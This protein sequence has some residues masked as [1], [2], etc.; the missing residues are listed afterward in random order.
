MRLRTVLSGAIFALTTL[1]GVGAFLYPFWMPALAQQGVMEG[2]AQDMAHAGDAAL[3]LS[4]IVALCFAVLLVEVQAQA[5]SAKA[6]A[7][8]GVLV[9]INSVLRFAEVA[10]PGPGGFSPIFLLIV[11]GGYVFGARIGFL[12]GALTLLASA[13]ITGGVGPWLPYQMLT[14]GWVGMSAPLCRGPARAIAQRVRGGE[15]MVLA[16]FGAAWG[17]LF[18]V[19]INLWFWPFTV[20]VGAMYW[21]PGVG[22]AETIRRYALFYSVTSLA[23]DLLRAAG[24]AVLIALLG[25]AV[26]RILERFRLRFDFTY[27][28]EPQTAG[29]KA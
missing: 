14:A 12:L 24:N 28:P 3:V 7:L 19:I 6:I 21:E 27:V 9:A 16:A 20:G 18:G 15:V 17:V 8:M 23:W 25:G 2:A 4:L 29:S 5:V 1:L 22:V 13:L 26:L 10:V 11:L